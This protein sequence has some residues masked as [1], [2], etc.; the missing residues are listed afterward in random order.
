MPEVEM[1]EISAETVYLEIKD[2]LSML[3]SDEFL[4]L[5]HMFLMEKESILQ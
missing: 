4:K 2:K 1:P 5:I 3:D